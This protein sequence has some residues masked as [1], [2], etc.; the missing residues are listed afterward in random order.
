[1]VWGGIL[2]EHHTNQGAVV[3]ANLPWSDSDIT[4]AAP[5]KSNGRETGFSPA[6]FYILSEYLC[7]PVNRVFRRST[8]GVIEDR[9]RLSNPE[10]WSGECDLSL[11]RG[12]KHLLRRSSENQK[13]SD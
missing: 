11:C 9:T 1:M 13:A 12:R 5:S 6:F 2:V 8:T 3:R 7:Y 4:F 10:L